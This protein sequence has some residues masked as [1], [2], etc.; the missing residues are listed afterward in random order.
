MGEYGRVQRVFP[1]GMETLF[2]SFMKIIFGVINYAYIL[3]K[4]LKSMLLL[5]T[6][7]W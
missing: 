5:G 4:L 6:Y 2:T 1:K 7:E 3:E